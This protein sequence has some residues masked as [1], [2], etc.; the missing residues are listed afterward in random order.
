MLMTTMLKTKRALLLMFSLMCLF[1]FSDFL[2]AAS[3][4]AVVLVVKSDER[5]ITIDAGKN[6][7]V[8]QGNIFHVFAAVKYVTLPF[9]GERKLVEI[10]EPVAVATVEKLSLD[11]S[12]CK[13]QYT[14]EDY[15]GLVAVG[16]ICR[17]IERNL[18][19]N[20]APVIKQLL[21]NESSFT[22]GLVTGVRVEYSDPNG[23]AP[24]FSWKADGAYF[25]FS[26]THYPEN[27]LYIPTDFSGANIA[28][29]VTLDDRKE[30]G[31]TSKVFEIPVS[32]VQLD[33][34]ANS[35]FA[36]RRTFS[37]NFTGDRFNVDDVCVLSTGEIVLLHVGRTRTLT[38]YDAK[39]RAV[40]KIKD[41]SKAIDITTDG[42]DIFLLEADKVSVYSKVGEKV[43]EFSFDDARLNYYIQE[44][45]RLCVRRNGDICVIDAR[46]FSVKVFDSQGVYKLTFGMAGQQAGAFLQPVAVVDD[47]FGNLFV[48][49]AQRKDI[50]KFSPE[51]VPDPA[52]IQISDLEVPYDLQYDPVIHTIYALDYRG[53][54]REIPLERPE[55]F[56]VLSLS[57]GVFKRFW[58]TYDNRFYLASEVDGT[59]VLQR[60]SPSEGVAWY[61]DDNFNGAADIASDRAGNI[62]LLCPDLKN[63]VVRTLDRNGWHF[64]SVI[65][66]GSEQGM[67]RDP[68]KMRVSPDGDYIFLLDRTERVVQFTS[69]GAY[70]AAYPFGTVADF[71]VDEAGV[72]YIVDGEGTVFKCENN[73]KQQVCNVSNSK[74]AKKTEKLAVFTGG[75]H[76]F[77]AN[78]RDYNILHF[79]EGNLRES[80]PS[81]DSPIKRFS[82][83]ET[84]APG[85]LLLLD[86]RDEKISTILLS[87]ETL[88]W[89]AATGVGRTV[90]VGVT[91]CSEVYALTE[92][93][94]I[95]LLRL[96]FLDHE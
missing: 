36:V 1:F 74:I 12:T 57:K 27:T 58:R 15:K 64:S 21:S 88:M 42:S 43:R 53:R 84:I 33:K 25:D 55:D 41:L 3:L 92:R 19:V 65:A 59:S 89:G 26:T 91:G 9:S 56:K 44:P 2:S 10:S 54:I 22:R 45:V 72:L 30:N 14:K 71:A 81:Q 85:L 83:L 86:G 17:R 40:T 95:T 77:I 48:L 29:E 24:V 11:T 96:P 35:Q 69:A 67:V 18:E 87:G 60:F 75:K 34:I 5:T 51:F 7:G 73:N 79:S 31:R 47:K 90:S 20:K 78:S 93:S 82:S 46:T 68:K 38:V 76:I 13:F 6:D 94:D 63:G 61:Q 80:F 32:Q 49:D 39:M 23:D 66:K 28:V 8:E 16:C 70:V 50:Q 37:M 62:Y 4:E 52:P